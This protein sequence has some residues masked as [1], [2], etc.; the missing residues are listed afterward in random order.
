M[1]QV[2]RIIIIHFDGRIELIKSTEGGVAYW[3][4]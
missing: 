3:I 1:G 2:Y 4:L